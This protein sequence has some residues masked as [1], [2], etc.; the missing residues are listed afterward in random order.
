MWKTGAANRVDPYLATQAA[1]QWLGE[2]VRSNH[3]DWILNHLRDLDL[4]FAPRA[5]MRRPAG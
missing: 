1:N 2:L 3:D 4:S 5:A